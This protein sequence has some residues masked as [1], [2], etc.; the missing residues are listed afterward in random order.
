MCIDSVI[1][2]VHK[3]CPGLMMANEGGDSAKQSS[4]FSPCKSLQRSVGFRTNHN[5]Q[6]KWTGHSD[7]LKWR[8]KI[9]LKLMPIMM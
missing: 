2:C 3:G 4:C 6:Y 9:K 7:K 1:E 5:T 8:F